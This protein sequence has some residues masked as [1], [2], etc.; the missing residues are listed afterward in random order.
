MDGIQSQVNRRTQMQSDHN[1]YKHYLTTLTP[2]S[3]SL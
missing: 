3:L 2:S 1:F